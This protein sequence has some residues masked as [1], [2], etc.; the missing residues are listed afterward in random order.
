VRQCALL[1][2]TSEGE[3]RIRVSN[4]NL[5]VTN[6]L[7]DLYTTLDVRSTMNVLLKTAVEQ[8]R[9]YFT[10]GLH[11]VYTYSALDVRS[12]MN[13]LLKTAVEQARTYF[14]PGSRLVRA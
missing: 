12:T 1:Y 13:V 6:N 14:T 8:A 10:P 4:L 9:T 7:A 11:L 3:R 5:P 2:T